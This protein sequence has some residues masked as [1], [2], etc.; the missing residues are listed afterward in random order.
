MIM[1]PRTPS[2]VEELS[3]ET[4]AAMH[5]IEETSAALGSAAR[6]HTTRHPLVALGLGMTAGYALGTRTGRRVSANVLASVGRIALATALS[7][8]ARG[9]VSDGIPSDHDQDRPHVGNNGRENDA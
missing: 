6:K 5:A 3:H 8:L 9:V 7:T 4:A 2:L 1:P